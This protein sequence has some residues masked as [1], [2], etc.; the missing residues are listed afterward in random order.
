MNGYLSIVSAALLLSSGWVF[1]AAPSEEIKE[2]EAIRLIKMALELGPDPIQVISVVEG[3]YREGEFEV[4]H[5]CR[6]T[7]L[8]LIKGPAGERDKRVEPYDFRWT[9]KY[10]WYL[11]FEME[12]RLGTEVHLF[13]EKMGEV[14]IR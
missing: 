2:D 3:T 9:A 14:V 7:T 1:A 13:S 10:G 4:P 12:G 6:V 11:Q 5:V 8:R